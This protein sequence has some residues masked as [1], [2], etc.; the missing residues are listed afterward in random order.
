[1]KYAM[2]FL[3]LVGLSG[4]RSELELQKVHH[5][6]TEAKNISYLGNEWTYFELEV[7]GKTRKFM[8][9]CHNNKSSLVELSQ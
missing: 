3:C 4:C 8:Y 7:G 1:M 5:I 2:I 9:R 6:P